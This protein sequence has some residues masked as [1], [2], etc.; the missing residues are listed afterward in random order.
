[1]TFRR[2]VNAAFLTA[3]AMIA[4]SVSARPQIV[5]DSTVATVSDGVRTELITRSDLLWQLALQPSVPLDP[6]RPEDLKQALQLQIDQRIFALEAQRLPRAAATEKDISDEIAELLK[7]FP[8]TA[9]FERRLRTVGFES[10]RDD[11]FEAIIAQRIAIERYLDFRF[12]SFVVIT[13][14]DEAAYYRDIWAGEFR[15]RNPSAIVPELARVRADVVA[16][17][18][19]ERVARNIEQFLEEAKRR[20]TVTILHEI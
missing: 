7:S 17:L 4:L 11:N 20:V 12:R 9:D 1:M 3:I 8:S 16:K 10:V 14:E 5:V 13:A 6:P 2:T 15:R 19:E 18:T